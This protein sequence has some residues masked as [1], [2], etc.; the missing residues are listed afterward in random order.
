M[1]Q[2]QNINKQ[3]DLQ[4]EQVPS[5]VSSDPISLCTTGKFFTDFLNMFSEVSRTSFIRH[6]YHLVSK[7]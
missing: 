2:G 5:E 3:E 1:Q 6:I 7:K 4:E